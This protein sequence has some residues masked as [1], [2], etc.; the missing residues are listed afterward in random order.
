ME[1]SFFLEPKRST[2]LRV[3]DLP[4]A[5]RVV[6]LLNA[7][8]DSSS[9]RVLSILLSGS[10]CFLYSMV[11]TVYKRERT[12]KIRPVVI[13]TRR[14]RLRVITCL[15]S[16]IC[17]RGEFTTCGIPCR[18]LLLRLVLVIGRVI[19]NLLDGLP[20]RSLFHI[21]SRRMTMFADRL[22]VLNSSRNSV[23]NST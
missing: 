23:L 13:S 6:F 12:V 19:G 21:L 2:F 20:K 7:V 5:V 9:K 16:G 1:P 10:L 4:G 22:A 17:L 18:T 3:P 8:S 15:I 11:S 14:L